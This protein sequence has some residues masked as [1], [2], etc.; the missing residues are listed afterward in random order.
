MQEVSQQVRAVC[1]PPSFLRWAGSKKQILP[2]LESLWGQ[3]FDR[4]VE[5]FAGSACLFFRLRPT[6]ARLSD[7]N[8]WLVE[9]QRGAKAD[10]A[11]VHTLS[12]VLSRRQRRTIIVFAQHSGWLQMYLSL[13]RNSSFFNRLCFNGIYRTNR[14]GEFNVPFGG[15]KSGQMVSSTT[16]Q[17]RVS[18]ARLS[19][20]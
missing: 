7:T 18:G 4:Y 3:R 9:T 1:G 13:P 19:R 15:G 6:N 16:T 10:L 14:S 20:N 17:E 11:R 8:E 5:P 2:E 12:R